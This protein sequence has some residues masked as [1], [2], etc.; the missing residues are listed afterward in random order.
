VIGDHREP[1][2]LR[3]LQLRALARYVTEDVYPYSPFYRAR[4]DAA[5]LGRQAPGDAILR[6]LPPTTFADIR[7]PGELVLRPDEKTIQRFASAKLL[8]KVAWAK[9]QRRADRVNREVID[10]TYKPVR[11]VIVD[12][13]TIGYTDDDIEQLAEEGRRWLALAGLGRYDV[14]VNVLPAAP[15]VAWWE[16]VE[17]A[18]LAGVSALHLPYGVTP[19]QLDVI[20]PTVVAGRVDDLLALLPAT[21]PEALASVHTVLAVGAPLND[22]VRASLRSALAP[23]AA[24][25]AAW[26]PPGVRSLWV[27]CR[28][29]TAAHVSPDVDL[30]EVV[31]GELVWSGLDWK[32]TALLR[33]RTG[34]TGRVDSSP[35]PV[36]GRTSPR[37]V[38][39]SLDP[40]FVTL[41]DA[42]PEVVAWQAELRTVDGVDELIVHL[43]V[44]AGGNGDGA[45]G[46]RHPGRV[47]RALD[48]EL[49][50]TQFVVTSADEVAARLRASGNRRVLD[51]RPGG[52]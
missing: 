6:S 20:R 52:R 14:I 1:A 37:V 48:R 50:V 5:G 22:D 9:F 3:A 25:V 26:A 31:D 8:V 29:G 41:L 33:L 13:V 16:L 36:C 38:G 18:R 49:S 47:L 51:H 44:D 11:W 40:R 45:A 35:C 34:A 43:A 24:V 21:S 2:Q 28:G 19:H 39:A 15:D 7:D 27:E 42:T 10:P 17:G 12:G 23:G 30:L 32:G 4:L 46:R